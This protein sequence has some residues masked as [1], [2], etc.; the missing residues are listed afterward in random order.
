MRKFMTIA[1]MVAVLP[2]TAVAQED[3]PQALAVKARQGF[4]EML[5]ANMGVSPRWPR[6]T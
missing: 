2:L 4:Y 5:N 6:A 1:A 3:S